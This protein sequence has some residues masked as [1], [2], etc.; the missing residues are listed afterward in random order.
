VAL[1]GEE[2]SKD[3]PLGGAVAT[4]LECA[5]LLGEGPVWVER[6]A[7]LYW[8][9]IAAPLIWRMD[10]AS[11]DVSH[12]T[13][14]FRICSLAPRVSSGFVAGTERGFAFVDPQRGSY[15]LIGD[16]EPEYPGN[17]FND[18]KIDGAGRFWAGTMDDS[19]REATGALYRLDANLSW[20]R[21][22]E[23]YRVTNG[24][25][26]SPDGRRIYHSDSAARTIFLFE[27]DEAGEVSTRRS[28]AQ[29]GEGEGHPDGMTTDAAGFLWVAFWDGWC[30]RRLSPEGACV[31]EMAMPV[32]RPTSCAFGGPA[33]DRLL[34]TSA[35]IGL[36]EGELDAQPLAG[37]L[38]MATPAVGGLPQPVFA[39]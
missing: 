31:E 27:L 4:I 32:Q 20:R 8:V 5:N 33:F 16:P 38:F 18:G 13:P 35:R 30:L 2:K 1:G 22:D 11:G 12:W 19:E 3:H 29:F 24:P 21:I 23:G 36:D 17:R 34:I 9:D 6:E 15:H 10:W 39:N 25:A 26:F 14:P 28:F 7:A 37:A